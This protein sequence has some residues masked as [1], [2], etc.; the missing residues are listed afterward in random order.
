[1]KKVITAKQAA[2]LIEE[3]MTIAAA[4]VGLQ[5]W[6]QEIA[7][8]IEKRF[9]E[10]AQPKNLTLVHACACGDH[11][12][13]N[14]GTNCLA[15][16][17]LI[18]RLITGHTGS[19]I[20]MSQLVSDSK[21]ECYLL[22][23]GVLPQLY[24]SMAGNKPGNI[25]K[26]GLHTF[27]DPRIEGGK[28]NDISHDDLVELME[29]DGEE[30]L[31][32]KNLKIDVAL[33]R[34]TICDEKGNMTMDEDITFMEML[35]L[36][37]AVKNNGGI[38]IAQ[39]KYLAKANS[40][41][42]KN[43]KIP[44]KLID[45]I[46]VS[47]SPEN[48]M[49]TQQTVFDP[50]FAGQ[51]KIALEDVP[52]LPLDA[53]KVIARRAAMEV[54]A[55][56]MVN[57]GIGVPAFVASI[58]AEE[59]L[60]DKITLTTEIGG[61]GGTPAAGLDFGAMYNAEAIIE[62]AAMFDFYDGGGLDITF[63]GLA[64]TDAQGN[65]NVSKLGKRIN[66]PGG[67]I[68]ISQNTKKVVFCGLFTNGAELEIINGGLRIEKEGKNNKFVEQ[69]LQ[70]TFSGKY[71]AQ[72]KQDVLFVT[73]RGVFKLVNQKLILIEIA[74]G[75]DLQKD[76]LDLMPFKPEVCPELKQMDFGLFEVKWGGLSL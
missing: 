41:P 9:L 15:H 12:D 24:R 18:K 55:G 27:V 37:E 76:I 31:R 62:H 2:G 38:V 70:V 66:G 50:A 60:S 5:G 40:L 53:K 71:A 75:V 73:E 21:A 3:S 39:V 13:N 47:S 52:S 63:L 30:W 33:L 34:G 16:E 46:V 64:Q 20:H 1:M 44:G 17:G 32:Y 26:V 35:P 22:P 28:A 4:T 6:P 68:N 42:P 69:V 14:R 45:H 67:F 7:W 8:E 65:V 57:L 58:L 59:N 11:Q 36:A 43:V 10:T 29:I 51:I 72:T 61:Y 48:H 56:D 49:Q 25:T 54:S 23:Q 19:A 74:K